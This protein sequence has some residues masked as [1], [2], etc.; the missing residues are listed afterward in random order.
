MQGQLSDAYLRIAGA[1][2]AAASLRRRG[3]PPATAPPPPTPPSLLP[4][5]E[6]RAASAEASRLGGGRT[7]WLKLVAWNGAFCRPYA[8][9]RAMAAARRDPDTR[10]RRRPAWLNVAIQLGQWDSARHCWL[11]S[12]LA[13]ACDAGARAL[14]SL[15]IGFYSSNVGSRGAL[16]RARRYCSAWRSMALAGQ[17]LSRAALEAAM[18]LFALPMPPTRPENEICAA[19][20]AADLA[21]DVPDGSQLAAAALKFELQ[22]GLDL[23]GKTG[24]SSELQART[25]DQLAPSFSPM[26]PSIDGVS[27]AW[28]RRSQHPAPAVRLVVGRGGPALRTGRTQRRAHIDCP[29]DARQA[30][31]AVAG[32]DVAEAQEAGPPNLRCSAT[33][34]WQEEAFLACRLLKSLIPARRFS[35]RKSSLEFELA[36]GRPADASRSCRPKKLAA[37]VSSQPVPVGASLHHRSG[38]SDPQAAA[39]TSRQ[40]PAAAQVEWPALRPF[41]Q[42]G[43]RRLAPANFVGLRVPAQQRPAR[44]RWRPSHRQLH[45]AAISGWS[46]SSE[47]RKTAARM[48]SLTLHGSYLDSPLEAGRGDPCKAHQRP[49]SASKLARLQLCS[50]LAHKLGAPDR[51]F[52]S[53]AATEA[54]GVAASAAADSLPAIRGSNGLTRLGSAKLI[55]SPELRRTPQ[56]QLSGRIG[57]ERQPEAGPKCRPRPSRSEA[58][59]AE[60]PI[61]RR[62]ELKSPTDRDSWR[63]ASRAIEQD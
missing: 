54:D 37:V 36:A 34:A 45:E 27:N 23:T 10:P 49:S 41:L 33:H 26:G 11:E 38:R 1:P 9:V 18:R 57:P 15:F 24:G 55:R 12:A 59:S 22:P 20:V 28:H 61:C 48:R 47:R 42:L 32:A 40:P 50:R 44:W 51:M 14:D 56:L 6:S 8:R 39:A 31:E 53:E 7:A 46:A 62:L 3:P 52:R 60:K 16:L 35:A 19:L 5:T 21:G 2:S 58:P 13:A 4:A 30:R 63:E 43:L 29:P 25:L 17:R